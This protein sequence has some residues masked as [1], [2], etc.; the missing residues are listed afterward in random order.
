MHFFDGRES[1]RRQDCRPCPEG[2]AMFYRIFRLI[3]SITLKLFYR[4][5]DVDGP[6]E[7]PDGPVLLVVNH[8]NA[9]VDP[10]IPVIVMKRRLTLTGKNVLGRN[11]LLALLN[12]GLGTIPFHRKEDVGKGA[13]LRQNVESMRRCRE[14]LAAG[15][16]VCVFPEGI[17]HSDLKMRT[18]HPGAARIAVDYVRKDQNPGNLK[19]VPVGLLYTSKGAFRSDAFMRVGPALD[20][21]EWATR[22]PGPAHEDL[23]EELR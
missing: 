19:I 1:G 5:I 8:T 6:R 23:T 14:V 3:A 17:S 7:L 4:R 2:R 13:D 21:G 15:G 20:V 12:W 16:T 9:L 22:H 11:P 18:F 10:L